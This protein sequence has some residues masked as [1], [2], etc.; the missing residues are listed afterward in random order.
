MICLVWEVIPNE[1]CL[2]ASPTLYVIA[3]ID[4]TQI[5]KLANGLRFSERNPWGENEGKKKNFYEKKQGL[6]IGSKIGTVA[7]AN[8]RFVNLK[9]GSF[10]R[11][12]MLRELRDD[13][14][15]SAGS[16]FL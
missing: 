7:L 15:K 12:A 16:G 13:R 1:I 4:V 11:H 8:F 6:L 2:L 10:N 14:D 3:R 5:V 9:R